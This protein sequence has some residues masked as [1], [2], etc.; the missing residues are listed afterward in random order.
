MG[1]S[2]TLGKRCWLTAVLLN[3]GVWLAGICLLMHG[4]IEAFKVSGGKFWLGLRWVL[5]S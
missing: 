5:R 1:L 4:T 2:P 3:R